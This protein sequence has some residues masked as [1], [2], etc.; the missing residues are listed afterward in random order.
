[1]R[2][3]ILI[4]LAFLAVFTYI[5]AFDTADSRVMSAEASI[6]TLIEKP[7]DIIH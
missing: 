4:L 2:N 6:E 5:R 1:M 7:I 3:L